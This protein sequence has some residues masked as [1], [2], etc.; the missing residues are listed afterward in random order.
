MAT[1]KLVPW[2]TT[3]TPKVLGP[4]GFAA[5]KNGKKGIERVE[6]TVGTLA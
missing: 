4:A 3:T 6:T 1:T 2:K 5:G